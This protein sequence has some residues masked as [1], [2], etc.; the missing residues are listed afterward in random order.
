MKWVILGLIGL[1]FVHIW[2]GYGYSRHDSVDFWTFADSMIARATWTEEEG[3]PHIPYEEA[4][5][6]ARKAYVD[7]FDS[8]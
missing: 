5:A 1:S 4:R 3:W 6:L 7:R 8:Q 2:R